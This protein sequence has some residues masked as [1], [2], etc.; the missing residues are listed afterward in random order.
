MV[1]FFTPED[2]Q[3]L[4]EKMLLLIK[5]KGLRERLSQNALRFV[6]DYSWDNKKE[7]YLNL[8]DSLVRKN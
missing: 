7:E 3:D 1:Q 6:A 4:A 2:D 8:V 5:N